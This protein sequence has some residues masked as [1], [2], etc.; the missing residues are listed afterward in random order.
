MDDDK[1]SPKITAR[2]VEEFGKIVELL[3]KLP[4]RVFDQVEVAEFGSIGVFCWLP[5]FENNTNKVFLPNNCTQISNFGEY[6][7]CYCGDYF[8]KIP[9]EHRKNIEYV[10]VNPNQ[11]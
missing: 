5:K 4:D 11:Q 1:K 3:N 6:I 9:T 2:S 8:F 10:F 7:G